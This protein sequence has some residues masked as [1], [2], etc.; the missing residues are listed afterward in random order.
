MDKMSASLCLDE[1]TDLDGGMS[2]S[3]SDGRKY[4]DGG[5][6]GSMH[7]STDNLY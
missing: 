7:S 4:V 5:T 2:I 3:L 6:G 1:M